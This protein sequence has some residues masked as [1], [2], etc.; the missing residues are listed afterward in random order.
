MILFHV[1]P[2]TG[3]F[4][5]FAAFNCANTLHPTILNL[6]PFCDKFQYKA[7][8]VNVQHWCWNKMFSDMTCS[9]C[10]TCMSS[11]SSYSI[12]WHIRERRIMNTGVTELI[13]M[14]WKN[15]NY[16]LQDFRVAWW[17]KMLQVV[18]ERKNSLFMFQPRTTGDTASWSQSC[19]STKLSCFFS[20]LWPFFQSNLPV[21]MFL[22]VETVMS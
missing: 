7:T 11:L 4:F 21:T 14:A 15:N 3:K 18:K 22:K 20:V 16:T 12:N 6:L 17:G 13:I 9:T 10:S 5:W 1:V 19:V 8:N 2:P